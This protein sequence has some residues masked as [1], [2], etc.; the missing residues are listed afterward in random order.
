MILEKI[1][2]AV[3]LSFTPLENEHFGSFGPLHSLPSLSKQNCFTFPEIKCWRAPL[4]RRSCYEVA[5]SIFRTPEFL[6]LI[7]KTKSFRTL[8]TYFNFGF[9]FEDFQVWNFVVF[10]PKCRICFFKNFLIDVIPGHYFIFQDV[11]QFLNTVYLLSTT[12][13]NRTNLA[14][15]SLIRNKIKH[16]NPIP[17]KWMLEQNHWFK[18]IITETEVISYMIT[19]MLVTSE[20]WWNANNLFCHQHLCSR[21]TWSK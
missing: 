7:F 10:W 1:F 6:I 11:T 12:S 13:G 20:C 8:F 5:D 16:I 21:N 15:S 18:K 17:T 14:I 9:N 3:P 2:R 19:V 4:H